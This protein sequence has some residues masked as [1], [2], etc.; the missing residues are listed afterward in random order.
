MGIDMVRTCGVV[1]QCLRRQKQQ[2]VCTCTEIVNSYRWSYAWT[3]LARE[4]SVMTPIA[5]DFCACLSN[6]LYACR[7][8]SSPFLSCTTHESSCEEGSLS[9]KRLSFKIF[10]IFYFIY[11]FFNL[12]YFHPPDWTRAKGTHLG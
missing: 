7:Y 2:I 6:C 8:N 11:I 1:G 9:I 10:R 5:V 12:L 4:C 3:S